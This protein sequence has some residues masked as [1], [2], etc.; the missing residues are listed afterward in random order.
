LDRFGYLLRRAGPKGTHA[1]FECTGRR[2][3][4]SWP[5]FL[6]WLRPAASAPPRLLAAASGGAWRTPSFSAPSAHCWRMAK[7]TRPSGMRDC[8]V[9][10]ERRVGRPCHRGKTA[11]VRL[12]IP[13]RRTVL[14]VH[15]KPDC[16]PP[17]PGLRITAPD[18]HQRN[19]L[20]PAGDSMIG[21]PCSGLRIFLVK[22]KNSVVPSVTSRSVAMSMEPL[23]RSCPQ[24]WRSIP[25]HRAS[26]GYWKGSCRLKQV[27][28]AIAGNAV[29]RCRLA[30]RS[31]RDC[32]GR[33]RSSSHRVPRTDARDL[34]YGVLRARTEPASRAETSISI[35]VLCDHPW[36]LLL[37]HWHHF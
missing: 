13:W 9:R 19:K 8:T 2:S 24:V 32:V 7:T 4:H 12:E 36:P 33:S 16:L 31:R 28:E 17:F 23:L 34:C 21:S 3:V 11:Y 37:S 20:R 27:F 22:A 1:G 10:S 25:R 18:P 6:A 5:K 29:Q 26:P 14:E 15:G 35:M 30:H